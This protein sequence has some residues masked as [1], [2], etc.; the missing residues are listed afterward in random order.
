MT[1]ARERMATVAISFLTLCTS[2]QPHGHLMEITTLATAK[3]IGEDGSADAS[4]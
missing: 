3:P 1:I 2:I 4:S